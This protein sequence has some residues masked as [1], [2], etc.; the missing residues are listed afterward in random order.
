MH[1]PDGFLDTKTWITTTVLGGLAVSYALQ[2]SRLRLEPH[3]V[4]QIALTGAFIFA[5]QMINFPVMGATSGHFLGGALA[6]ILFGPWVGTILIACVLIIQ[7]LIF[8]DGGITVLGANILCCAVI[9]SWI[10]FAIYRVS[11]FRWFCA[12][13]RWMAFFAFISGWV[14]IVSAAM[15][16][17]VLLAF[18]G[19]VSWAVAFGAMVS[20]HGVIG[21]GEGLITAMVF[22]YLRERKWVPQARVTLSEGH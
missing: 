14:S 7:A 12:S 11:A 6:A 22:L 17:A 1:I 8:Q 13:S 2:K 4:P 21:V 20:W 16:V 19:T 18:S 9:G 15:G 5:A 3:Q 10:G